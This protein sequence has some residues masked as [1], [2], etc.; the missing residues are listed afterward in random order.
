[1]INLVDQGG[2]LGEQPLMRYWID[3]ALPS[4]CAKVAE[5]SS[6]EAIARKGRS[7]RK[8]VA[9]RAEREISEHGGRIP[10]QS[11]LIIGQPIPGEVLK[12]DKSS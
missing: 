12:V 8:R 5:S 3:D 6:E 10:A 1:M 2:L 4:S 7:D 11:G 9:M